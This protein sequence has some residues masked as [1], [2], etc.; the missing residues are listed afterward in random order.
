MIGDVEE[1][2]DSSSHA[3]R[4]SHARDDP[5]AWREG[6]N[7]TFSSISMTVVRACTLPNQF[8]S[9]DIA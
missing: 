8:G 2:I 6:K 4:P 1:P 5:F 7:L 9:S 3:M